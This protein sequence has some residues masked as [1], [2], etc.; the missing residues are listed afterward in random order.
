MICNNCKKDKTESDFPYKNKKLN[1]RSTICKICQRNYKK[2]YY[3]LNKESHYIRNN[4]TKD[5][6]ITF[7]K[8]Y[9]STLSCTMCTENDISCI[10]FHHI[11][12]KDKE[13]EISRLTIYGSLNKLKKELEKCI[14]LCANCHRKLH[15][16]KITL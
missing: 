16:G 15:A 8:N 6:L 3:H 5:F 7:I 4:K 12:P 11:N 2:K 10:D 14:P 9:K 13:F 1:K